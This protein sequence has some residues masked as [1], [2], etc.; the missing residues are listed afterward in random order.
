MFAPLRL[1]IALR[2]KGG[3]GLLAATAAS[4]VVFVATPF[5]IGPISAEF[6]VSIGLAAT[7][8]TAQLAGFV[9]A[10]A[11][12]PRVAHPDRK[13]ALIAISVLVA[14]NVASSLAPIF[15]VFALTR[16][17]AG[18]AL[19]LI[20]WLAWHEAFGDGER[21]KDVA[22]VGPLVGAVASPAM[23]WLASRHDLDAVYLV[24]AGICLLP[25]VFP[26]HPAPADPG[27]GGPR[28]R[29]TRG[30]LAILVGLGLLTLGGSSVFVLAATIGKAEAGMT[31]VAVSLAYGLNSV[32]GIPASRLTPAR[33]RPGLWLATTAGA[34]ALLA[35]ATNGVVFTAAIAWWGFSFWMGVPAAFN[36]LAAKSRYPSERAGDAQSVMA[37][38]RVIGP[39]LGGV[40]FEAGSTAALGLV[41]G[42]LM[43]A[44]ALI[45]FV[46]DKRAADPG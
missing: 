24:L 23:G 44:S 8:S 33:A 38:G 14:S 37:L 30:A 42:A 46:V 41:A 31:A 7:A 18:F 28:H 5:L 21:M 11:L 6:G 36:L 22:V 43:A 26:M 40:L 3:I 20:A 12:A 2:T 15:G 29:P 1:L 19:G 45:M 4:T 9:L 17:V 39:V 34:A 25:L 35:T 16:S 10:T 32:A 27:T 13:A